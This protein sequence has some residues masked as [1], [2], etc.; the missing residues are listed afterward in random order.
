MTT[1]ERQYS[2]SFPNTGEIKEFLA[3]LSHAGVSKATIGFFESLASLPPDK[4]LAW[5][6][7]CFLKMNA[8]HEVKDIL[9][10]G[11]N[12][13]EKK[14]LI[15]LDSAGLP[16]RIR[17][18]GHGIIGVHEKYILIRSLGK[19]FREA[20]ANKTQYLRDRPLDDV[21]GDPES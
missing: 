7:I 21:L 14:A 11:L 10:D 6:L 12:K 5:S 17:E 1:P 8:N 3:A 19:S 4:R 18:L 13:E 2:R 9:A 15:E 20:R 16:V